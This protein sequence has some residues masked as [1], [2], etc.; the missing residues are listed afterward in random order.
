[1]NKTFKYILFSI[2]LAGLIVLLGIQNTFSST[3]MYTIHFNPNGGSVS[4][5]EKQYPA[6][7]V[8]SDLPKPTRDGY[9]FEGWFLEDYY[10]LDYN[11]SFDD[12]YGQPVVRL[13][14]GNN[15]NCNLFRTGQ[16][17]IFD[18][19]IDNTVPLFVDINDNRV[20]S[21]NYTIIGNRIYG[22]IEFQS[23]Y[24]N[25]DYSFLDIDCQ[26]TITGYTV[27]DYK[28]LKGTPGS[29][30][31]LGATLTSD[32]NVYAKWE[33]Q[34]YFTVTFVPQ[35]EGDSYDVS[36]LSGSPVAEQSS[37]TREGY[38][39]L[40]WY[41]RGEST[42]YNFNTPV[43]DNI[44]IDAKWEYTGTY[45][46]VVITLDKPVNV[47]T[48]LT[49]NQRVGFDILIY[50]KL[51]KQR[52]LSDASYSEITNAD[53]KVLL[54]FDDN[55]VLTP[56]NGLTADD[57]I[58]YTFT[59]SEKA[60]YAERDVHINSV[61]LKFADKPDEITY[62]DI[63]LKLRKL[64]NYREELTEEERLVIEFLAEMEIISDREIGDGE[65]GFYTN[66]GKLLFSANR[67][68]T[69]TPAEGLTSADNIVHILT[70]D[71]KEMMA[72]NGYY[73]NTVTLSFG[74]G[75]SYKFIEGAGQTYYIGSSTGPRFKADG[76]LS[77]LK[78]IRVDKTSV[79][80]KC[81]K[82]SGSTIATIDTSYADTL[83][84]GSHT[85]TFVYSDGQCST[86]FTVAQANQG[87][88]GNPQPEPQPVSGVSSNVVN[89][90]DEI[91]T[92]V[93]TLIVTTTGLILSVFYAKNLRYGKHSN[94]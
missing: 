86:N 50:K 77:K 54:K 90:G 53:G 15:Y 41:K 45:E 9:S 93:S 65:F 10:S 8:L 43:N 44:I 58:S 40:G 83:S 63:V 61:T 82:E 62:S 51:L 29:N 85:I 3:A 52:F 7:T 12:Y 57:N 68:G 59:E 75:A 56:E 24:Y 94:Y 27:N 49:Y 38:T 71:E 6:E 88:G 67:N 39:F 89:T 16:T 30:P 25:K 48:D 28:V 18:V 26:E 69:L 33:E 37:P 76:D 73:I 11:E 81:K 13:T 47:D 21:S 80:D 17:I 42:P 23:S 31:A 70:D 84:L 36:V 79:L 46:D 55:R 19:T 14:P 4:P 92:Y 91:I 60:T 78:D 22:K 20:D 66:E 35:N 34:T 74:D 64:T 1:M 5:T 2:V 87:G 32:I 72:S